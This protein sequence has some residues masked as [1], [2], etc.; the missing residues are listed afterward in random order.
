M[1]RYQRN[2]ELLYETPA[3][4]PV[5]GTP[6]NERLRDLIRRAVAEGRTFLNEEESRE[7]LASYGIPVAA[8]PITPDT[9]EPAAEIIDSTEYRLIL[10]SR[11]HTDFGSVIFFGMGGMNGDFLRDFSIGLPPLNQTLARRLIEDTKG[12]SVLQSSRDKPSA[13][14]RDLETVL[15]GFSYLIA[16]FPEIAEMEINPVAVSAGRPCALSVRITLDAA[17]LEPVSRYPHLVITPYPAA[18]VT[19]WSLPDGTGIVLRPIRPE[20]ELMEREFVST[21]SEES[22]RTRFFSTLRNVSHEWLVMYCSIDYDR[23][24]AIVAEVTEKEERRIIGVARIVIEPD[25]DSGEIAVLVHDRFQGKGLGQKLM[26][27]VLEIARWKGL[28]EVHGEVL[29]DNQRMVRLC[30]RL[31]FSTKWLVGGTTKISMLLR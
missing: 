29:T 24:I 1:Y 21:L 22:Q 15:V 31:G 23:H 28:R 20:D 30:A 3:E 18:F 2:L 27:V 4:L 8:G 6:G 17:Y 7:F 16:D 13:D 26:E 5:Q 9:E 25:F 19:R 11:R 10:G 12:Y 14:L